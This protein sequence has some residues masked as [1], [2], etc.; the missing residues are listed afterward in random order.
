M[1][2]SSGRRIRKSADGH[3]SDFARDAKDAETLE[4]S[5]VHVGQRKPHHCPE[6]CP[7]SG[8]K[9]PA[10]GGHPLGEPLAIEDVARLLG[11]SVWTVRQKYLPQGLP[12]LRV[13]TTG[14]FVFFR[15][16]VI[17]WILKRQGKG[18]TK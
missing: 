16:Q 18:G 8:G 14:K 7:H 17:D 11:C 9:Q 10:N 15:T 2:T 6:H 1:N 4:G 13:S 12:Y 3:E 5:K